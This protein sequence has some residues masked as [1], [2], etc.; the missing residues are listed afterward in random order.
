MDYSHQILMGLA[1][2]IHDSYSKYQIHEHL[3]ILQE[4]N[5]LLLQKNLSL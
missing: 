1:Q 2:N 3:K 4:S 5:Y